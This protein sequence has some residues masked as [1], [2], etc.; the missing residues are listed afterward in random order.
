MEN[1]KIIT[2]DDYIKKEIKEVYNVNL[3]KVKEK[4]DSGQE[5]D[6]LD[7]S[8]LILILD[9]EEDLRKVA[10]GNEMLERVVD[11]IIEV[12]NDEEIVR[13]Y[14]EEQKRIK[15]NMA[16]K[17]LKE[18][19]QEVLKEIDMTEEEMKKIIDEN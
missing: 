5:L 13:E 16:I 15:K 18:K 2:R 7:R 19:V 17:L 10:N 12:N 8:L 14:T 6:D 9:N 11:K 3:A 4:Y 1:K